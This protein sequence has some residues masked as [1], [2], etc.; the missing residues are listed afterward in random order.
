MHIF[1]PTMGGWDSGTSKSEPAALQQYEAFVQGSNLK[2]NEFFNNNM[3][4]YFSNNQE[5]FDFL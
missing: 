5:F 2:I 1:D 4:K 3:Y